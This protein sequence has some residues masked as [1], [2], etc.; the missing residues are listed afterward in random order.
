MKKTLTVVSLGCAKNLVDMEYMVGSLLDDG[1][2]MSTDE[3]AGDMVL[4]NTCAFLESARAE[5]M[6]EISRWIEKKRNGSVGHVIV[7]GCLADKYKD[8]IKQK[9]NDVDRVV[10]LRENRNIS[11]IAGEILG[12]KP[13]RT[14][15][16]KRVLLTRPH[17]AY[18]KLSDGC[19]NRCS[20]CT[21]PDIRGNFR[22]RPY[23]EILDEAA[24]LE[25]L[26]TRE[27]CLI[28]QD[29][30]LYGNDLYGEL[31]LP[32][33]LSEL[34]QFGGFRWIRLLYCHP[35]HISPELIETIAEQPKVVP[36]LDIPIQ[37]ISTKILKAMNRRIDRKEL[38]SLFKRIRDA[39]PGLKLRT[40]VMV[41]FPGETKY[42]FEDLL[43]WLSYMR[44]ERL[45]AFAY[46]REEDTSA[47]HLTPQV[48][49]NIKE[50]RLKRV[51]NNQATI[52][53]WFNQTLMGKRIEVLVDIGGE[54]PVGRTPWDVPE[55][56]G[57]VHLYG[58]PVKEG[59]FVEVEVTG[60]GNYDLEARIIKN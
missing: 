31:R 32:A 6:E 13:A 53:R 22:S 27:I 28:S 35:A 18:L 38:K 60:C 25:K 45:G 30:A 5:S 12:T 42:D 15:S 2:E 16:K 19:D 52:S 44:F 4:V 17:T 40:T 39:I 55:E 47:Y 59:T 49:E 33:L 20:Y 50:Q 7:T 24:G 57:V 1:Y 29:T 9:I 11:S 51:L 10:P 14:Q 37:H 58:S 56:D 8:M 3:E 23:E 46:S 21:I 36:Y 41:G 54:H 48:P 26:G 34:S 43:T